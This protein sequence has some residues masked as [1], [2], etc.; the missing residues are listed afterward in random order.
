MCKFFSEHFKHHFKRQ[1]IHRRCYSLVCNDSPPAYNAAFTFASIAIRIRS[2]KRPVATITSSP[3]Y[4]RKLI[5]STCCYHY[6]T[7]TLRS[8]STSTITTTNM[9]EPAGLG[10]LTSTL[11]AIGLSEVP[12]FPETYPEINPA[13][14]YRSHITELLTPLTNVEPKVVHSALSWTAAPE[15]GDL[16]LPVPALRVKGKKPQEFAQELSDKV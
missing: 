11:K 4:N 16:L 5:N 10:E 15:K 14:I 6:S 3:N 8:H 2:V 13:D 7:A 9:P 12:R 1:L